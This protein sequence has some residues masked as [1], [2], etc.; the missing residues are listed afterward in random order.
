[1]SLRQ[2]LRTTPLRVPLVT[3]RHRGIRDSDV[4][5][6]SYPRSGSSWLRLMLARLAWDVEPDFDSIQHLF[7]DVGRHL[8]SPRTRAGARLI[9]SHERPHVAYNHRYR[10]VLYLV[11]DGR[12]VAVSYYYYL[13]S[14]GR[15]P[16][17]AGFAPFLD[18][19]CQ[20][21]LDGY[22]AWHDHVTDWLETTADLCLIRYEDLKADPEAQLK[23][24]AEFLHLPSDNLAEAV[25]HNSLARMKDQER[26]SKFMQSRTVVSIPV[27]RAGEVG[28][29][30]TVF[31]AK[32]LD[33]F[34]SVSQAALRAA[35]YS[36]EP[37][38]SR[39]DP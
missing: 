5:L 33:R 32:D 16:E 39:N 31:S 36:V 10:R 8:S 30:R 35:G 12:D 20:G 23:R 27:V 37:S 19:F 14:R 9:K 3:Y 38:D 13:Q 4:F 2:R 18:A 6:V 17:G 15:L 28:G 22:G 24:A 25:R 11:R 29:W 7:P 26:T 34:L 1:M 21:R